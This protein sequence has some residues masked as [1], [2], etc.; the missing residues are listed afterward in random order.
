MNLGDIY[1]RLHKRRRY[2][3]Q[4]CK[5]II[6]D[7]NK[8]IIEGLLEDGFVVWD[9]IGRFEVYMSKPKM[10]NY[11]GIKKIKIPSNYNVHV[12]VSKRLNKEV[13]KYYKVNCGKIIKYGRLHNLAKG[14]NGRSPTKSYN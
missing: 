5:N 3:Y 13:R 7:L 4:K 1:K 11:F 2:S 14:K 9:R 6:K 10:V 8:I 12:R